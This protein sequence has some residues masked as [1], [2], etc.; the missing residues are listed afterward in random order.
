LWNQTIHS[1][2]TRIVLRYNGSTMKGGLTPDQ[3]HKI[4]RLANL[5]LTSEEVEKFAPQ[6]SAILEFVSKLQKIPTKDVIPTSQVNGLENVYREDEIDKSRMLTQED[7]L[8]NAP[9]THNGFF[10]VK[11]V[12]GE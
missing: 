6:L 4:A 3:V 8:A 5:I 7:A 1:S 11:A 2:G 10:K 12:F 9:A